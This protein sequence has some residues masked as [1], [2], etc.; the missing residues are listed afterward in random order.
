MSAIQ[1]RR[2]IKTLLATKSEPFNITVMLSNSSVDTTGILRS[3][4]K[5]EFDT[6][7]ELAEYLSRKGIRFVNKSKRIATDLKYKTNTLM[8]NFD[9]A[10]PEG[11]FNSLV[12]ILESFGKLY[13]FDLKDIDTKE[14]TNFD[15][16]Y[17]R[18][19]L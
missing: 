17:F 9:I 3:V 18:Y 11:P 5:N 12:V 4:R 19:T 10:N 14:L 16:L 8:V 2:L 13:L 1:T 7:D 15:G 6:I